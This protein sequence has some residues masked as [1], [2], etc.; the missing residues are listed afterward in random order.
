MD[1]IGRAFVFWIV[2]PG[3]FDTRAGFRDRRRFVIRDGIFRLSSGSGWRF[4]KGQRWRLKLDLRD[5]RRKRAVGV[6]A[7]TARG[8]V[9]VAYEVKPSRVRTKHPE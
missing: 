7:M 1:P 6:V 3:Q 9:A 5:L 2:A 8:V 4:S